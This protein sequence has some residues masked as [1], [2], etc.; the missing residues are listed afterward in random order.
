MKNVGNQEEEGNLGVPG[1]RE[2][3]EHRNLYRQRGNHH[4]AQ[5]QERKYI[6]RVSD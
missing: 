3:G 4:S 5:Q 1:Q 6:V 2:S